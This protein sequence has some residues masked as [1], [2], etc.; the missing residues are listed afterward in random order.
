MVRFS[1]QASIEAAWY[2]W[3]GPMFLLRALKYFLWMA[4][5][6][7]F[8]YVQNW[9]EIILIFPI[10]VGWLHFA[11]IEVAQRMREKGSM[12]F[13]YYNF[14]NLWQ[15][16]TLILVLVYTILN[17][18]DI[19]RGSILSQ[20]NWIIGVVNLFTLINFLDFSRGV[21]SVS[22]ILFALKMLITKMYPF[23]GTSFG[24]WFHLAANCQE[25]MVHMTVK[26]LYIS[27]LIHMQLQCLMQFHRPNS[28]QNTKKLRH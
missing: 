20:H 6:I 22:W 4:C 11:K 19:S 27:L 5:I 13:Y 7:S 21:E 9:V 14:W 26:V 16:S 15:I 2:S 8:D 10:I 25:L 1:L 17:I 12:V 3:A 18:V 28:V 24:F 23:L